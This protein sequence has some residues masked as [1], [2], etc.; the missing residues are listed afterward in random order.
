MTNKYSLGGVGNMVSLNIN[1]YIHSDMGKHDM[2]CLNL[3]KNVNADATAD[4]SVA[5]E[6]T[7]TATSDLKS[8]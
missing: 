4:T 3:A 1:F 6:D 2:M 8:A 7:A 5:T